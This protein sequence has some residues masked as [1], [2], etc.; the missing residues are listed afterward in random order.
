MK[1]IFLLRRVNQFRNF[2]SIIEAALRRGYAVELWLGLFMDEGN[3]KY[4]LQPS[5]NNVPDFGEG[6]IIIREYHSLDE[7][8]DM[9]REFKPDVLVSIYHPPNSLYIEDRDFLFVTLQY[10]IDTIHRSSKSALEYTD[11][12]CLYTDWWVDWYAEYFIRRDG[13]EPDWIETHIKNKS[14]STG[15]P[16][17]DLFEKIDP[18]EVRRNFNIAENQPVVLYLPLGVAMWPGAWS[19][20]LNASSLKNKFFLLFEGVKED[21]IK[22]FLKYSPWILRGWNDRKLHMAIRKFAENNGALFLVK[23]RKKETFRPAIEN[24][25]H[26]G[27]YDEEFYPPTSL[28]LISIADV[29]IHAY[30]T[31]VLESAYIGVPSITIQRPNLKMLMHEMWRRDEEGSA[32][33]FPGV[34][35]LMS[36]PKIIE[37]LPNHSLADFDLDRNNH[38]QFLTNFT[39]DSDNKAGERVLQ[40]IE[41][42]QKSKDNR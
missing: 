30:S 11:L 3:N 37:T 9:V 34:S 5:S 18:I 25:M 41:E 40:A 6:N 17:L 19:K 26:R 7:L 21:G 16:Q 2:G 20:F 33:N 29:V 24:A 36:I 10:G 23:G 1:I 22:F 32:F 4:Y 13:C 31:A 14:I 8:P 12:I 28:E 15:F 39:G 35:R 27:V 38:Q 42:K